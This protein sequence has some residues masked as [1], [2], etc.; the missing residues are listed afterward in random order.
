[1]KRESPLTIEQS[2]AVFERLEDKT[3]AD[4]VDGENS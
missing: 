4:L 2:A 1:L 3:S